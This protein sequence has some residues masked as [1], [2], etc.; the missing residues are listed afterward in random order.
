ML[1]AIESRFSHWDTRYRC[2]G[3]TRKDFLSTI[4]L[5]INVH[6]LNETNLDTRNYL[7]SFCYGHC[8][9]VLIVGTHGTDAL[10]MEGKLFFPPFILQLMFIHEIWQ[11]WTLVIT[12]ILLV[13]GT[14]I[15]FSTL[16]NKILMLWI[17]EK[18]FSFLHFP[19]N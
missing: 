17:Y 13:V 1:C 18:S 9:H 3:Y 14:T 10:D 2:F 5:I 15:T 19:Y 4:L 16:G 12:S 6:P 11:T 7:R 8:T